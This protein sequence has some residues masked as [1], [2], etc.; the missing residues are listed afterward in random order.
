MLSGEGNCR[1]KSF[2]SALLIEA[3]AY[4]AVIVI[5]W[6]VSLDTLNQFKSALE[7]G[8]EC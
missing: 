2:T 4:R 8:S 3:I 5:E 1:L 6:S 7:R